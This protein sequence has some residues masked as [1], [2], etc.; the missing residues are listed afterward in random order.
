MNALLVLIPIALVLAALAVG[1]FFWAVKHDQFEDL[2]SPGALPLLDQPP[3]K[4]SAKRAD[5]SPHD[6]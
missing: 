1:I 2:D 6:G 3:R 4:D 5:A